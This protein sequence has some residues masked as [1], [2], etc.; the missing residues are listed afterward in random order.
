MVVEVHA[1]QSDEQKRR[2][3]EWTQQM[4]RLP[5]Q[6]RARHLGGGDAVRFAGF[7]QDRQHAEV[8]GVV[9]NQERE[10]NTQ[11]AGD[12]REIRSERGR[13][14]PHDA[15]R[16][17]VDHLGARQNPRE[18]ARREDQADDREH[19]P[20][21]S[22]DERFLLFDARIVEQYRDRESDHEQHGQ[23]QHAFDQRDEQHDGEDRVDGQAIGTTVRR[24]LVKLGIRQL[25]VEQVLVGRRVRTDHRQPRALA[26]AESVGT[27][28]DPERA[29]DHR[30]N[31]RHEDRV[32]IDR[33][34]GRGARGRPTPRQNVHD[35]ARQHRHTGENE[36][37]DSQLAVEG[38][39]RSRRDH[40]RR[41]TVAIERDEQGKRRG[42][43]DDLHRIT[44]HQAHEA[45][46]ER[47]EQSGV[48]HH[49]EVQNREHQHD[50]GRRQ[51]GDT[52]DHHL[53]ELRGEAAQ[54][55]EDDR[56]EDQGRER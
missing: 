37:S 49:R 39:H 33:E 52:T 8:K 22:R 16:H 17:R 21:V 18:H 46:H 53:A 34:R 55:A 25:F 23:W 9:G 45:L 6:R 4:H 7:R 30:R 28:K 50:T 47:L 41:R 40:V 5:D 42:P 48:D 54:H 27:V 15:V 56:D 14:Q 35:A 36:R 10:W 1:G 31:E 19:V 13:H 29:K 43:H 2:R 11:N 20:G 32:D 38:Q 12:D 26:H 3:H 44:V 51:L 24:I